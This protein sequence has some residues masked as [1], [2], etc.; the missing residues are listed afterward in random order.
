MFLKK[1]IEWLLVHMA[2]VI[3]S[4]EAAA[5]AEVDLPFRMEPMTALTDGILA[6]L[7]MFLAGYLLSRAAGRRSVALW[8]WGFVVMAVCAFDGVMYHSIRVAFELSQI[9]VL[10]RIVPIST[11]AAMCCFGCAAAVAWLQPPVRKVAIVII[12][13]QFLAASVW[14]ATA[15]STG[16]GV[17][18]AASGPVLAWLLIG[19]AVRR[20]AAES[21]WIIPGVLVMGIAALV[22]SREGLQLGQ[23][24]NNDIFHIIQMAAMVLL[25]RGGA[26]LTDRERSA[27]HVTSE[28]AH[29]GG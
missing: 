28:L 18:V 10:W 27:V 11:A 13:A 5:G 17:A 29:A 16:F 21:R 2:S 7:S 1:P 15:K 14:A 20:H 8:G 3:L 4:G 24:D 19:A 26:L 23:F 6:M 12:I 9:Q 22:Q 25:Y